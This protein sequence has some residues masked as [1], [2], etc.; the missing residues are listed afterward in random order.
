M[1][2]NLAATADSVSWL[3]FTNKI[4]YAKV[5]FWVNLFFAKD[6]DVGNFTAGQLMQPIWIYQVTIKTAK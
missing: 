5:A 6:A 3:V 4:S 2:V 1:L